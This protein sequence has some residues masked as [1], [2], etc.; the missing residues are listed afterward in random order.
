[1]TYNSEIQQ[2]NISFRNHK[3]VY[4]RYLRW[5]YDSAS[6]LYISKKVCLVHKT[7]SKLET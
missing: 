6:K 4:K 3:V 2:N 5:S 7:F 1:M